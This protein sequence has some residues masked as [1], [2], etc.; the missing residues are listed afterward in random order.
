LSQLVA[1]PTGTVTLLFT[2]VEGSSRQWEADAATTEGLV[3]AHDKL[4]RSVI[5]GYERAAGMRGKPSLLTAGDT[6]TVAQASKVLSGCPYPAN[7]RLT[8]W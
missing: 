4:V 6:S 8:G 3:A 1:R 5:E 2:D 7:G